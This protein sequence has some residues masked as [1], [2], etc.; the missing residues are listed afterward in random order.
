M[1]EGRSFSALGL[2]FL[3]KRSRDSFSMQDAE[4][5]CGVKS[6]IKIC[7]KLDYFICSIFFKYLSFLSYSEF[8]FN[9]FILFLHLRLHACYV[10]CNIYFL[11]LLVLFTTVQFRK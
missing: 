11:L 6:L 3:S 1:G 7:T 2:V 4:L 9:V 8:L 5:F 10:L